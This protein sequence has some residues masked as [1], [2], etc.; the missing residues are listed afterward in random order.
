[1]T[2]SVEVSQS[3]GTNAPVG[4]ANTTNPV[5]VRVADNATQPLSATNNFKVT[6]NSLAQPSM[7]AI[8]LL[9]GQVNLTITGPVGPDYTLWT[10]TNLISW[11]IDVTTNS[12][13]TPFVLVD[14]NR[15]DAAR[16]YRVQLVP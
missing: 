4:Y 13:I 5:A 15:T 1:M 6:V 11:Q 7:D 2:F 3:H 8:T 10:S 16:F 14:T 12:P 9:P